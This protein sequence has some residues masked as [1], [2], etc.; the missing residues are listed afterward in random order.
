MLSSTWFL[1]CYCLL[2]HR[3]IGDGNQAKVFQLSRFG[4][5]PSL[6]ASLSGFRLRVEAQWQYS[7]V[8]W[9]QPISFHFRKRYQILHL[10]PMGVISRDSGLLDGGK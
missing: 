9:T 7:S 5:L 1:G 3:T 6:Q 2:N 4:L 8:S 10:F